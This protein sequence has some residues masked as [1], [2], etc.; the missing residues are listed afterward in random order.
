MNVSMADGFNLGWKLAAV[1]R[2]QA[3][4][5]LLATYSRER[6]AVANELIEFDRELARRIGVSAKAGTTEGTFQ[7]FFVE[8]GKYT[9]GVATFYT[10]GLLTG[11]ATNQHLAN[12]YEIGKR[13]HSSQVV[14]IAD[15]KFLHLGHVLKADGRWRII[16]FA[17]SDGLDDT[18]KFL[19]NDPTSPINR[20]TPKGA[21][22]DSVIDVRA[23]YQ[24]NCHNLEI[25]NVP[26]I[27]FPDKGP[28]N[29][30]DFEKAFC[31][32]LKGG[33]D[34]YDARG[35]DRKSG[36]AL[37]VRPDQYVSEVLRLS[38]TA[39]MSAFFDKFLLRVD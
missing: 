5:D 19:A 4:P 22:I 3:K 29:L 21:D 37:I 36:C 1:I 34:I 31:S 9:A 13:F 14:R 15:G 27:L 25:T 38:D 7:D 16:L 10:P 33:P 8:A 26:D 24:G 18:C 2:G 6:Q 11:G 35:I 32:E 20:H 23:V 28:L 30:R 17:G 39:V 12:G